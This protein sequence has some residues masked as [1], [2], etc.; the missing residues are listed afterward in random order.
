MKT[1]SPLEDLARYVSTQEAVPFPWVVEHCHDGTLDA[2]WTSG[3]R[4]VDNATRL[5][6][7]HNLGTSRAGRAR[8]KRAVF[9][10]VAADGAA[11]ESTWINEKTGEKFR[12]RYVETVLRTIPRIVK[13]LSRRIVSNA[14][15]QN[16]LGVIRGAAANKACEEH[17][18]FNARYQQYRPSCH[19]G[20]CLKHVA[21]D[22]LA[23]S[24]AR[25]L[26]EAVTPTAFL[27]EV[28]KNLST[29]AIRRAILEA[30]PTLPLDEVL[31][32]RAP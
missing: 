8:L 21:H 20:D 15:M 4:H 11:V 32:P 14:S 18:E 16:L 10:I 2:V 12:T 3:A 27:D 17:G 26:A 7:L 28:H 30:V 23:L 25:L 9:A 24:A 5:E 19:R 1:R 22:E 29:H 13:I 31:T 6:L